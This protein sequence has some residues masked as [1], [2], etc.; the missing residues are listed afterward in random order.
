MPVTK[1]KREIKDDSQVFCCE[2]LGEWTEIRKT[3]VGAQL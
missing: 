2:Q 1:K 3:G